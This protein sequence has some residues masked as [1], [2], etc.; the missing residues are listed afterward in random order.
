M[1]VK[2]TSVLED[3]LSA[4][5]AIANKSGPNFE[6]YMG[7]F[8]IHLMQGLQAISEPRVGFCFFCFVFFF[9]VCALNF[10]V[11]VTDTPLAQ[12]TTIALV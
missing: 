3:A 1:S 12:S 10:A 11:D 7:H 4:V 2:N 6:K 9:F 8:K 5:C